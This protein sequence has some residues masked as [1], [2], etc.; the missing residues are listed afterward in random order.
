MDELSF[1]RAIGVDAPRLSEI[2]Y[3][4]KKHWGYSEEQLE[5]WKSV[6]EV[7]EEELAHNVYWNALWED[8]VVGF[9]SFDLK[10]GFLDEF[11]LLPELIGRGIGRRMFDRLIEELKNFGVHSIMIVSDPN[12]QPFYEHMG[13][14]V[15][16]V[17]ESMAKGRFLPVLEYVL[18][19]SYKG[20]DDF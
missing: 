1:R 14:V 11:Y 10:E 17:Q 12:A 15:V 13:A 5:S 7:S 9:F 2:S 16:G 4:S 18:T 8:E 19:A 3:L 20:Y 6:I